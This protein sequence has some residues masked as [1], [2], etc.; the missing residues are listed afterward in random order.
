[1]DYLLGSQDFKT[2]T[3]KEKQETTKA[4]S[5]QGRM[6]GSMQGK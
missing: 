4:L 6:G 2:T 5:F 3:R 1:V